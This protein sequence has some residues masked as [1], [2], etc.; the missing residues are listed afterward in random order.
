MMYSNSSLPYF[1]WSVIRFL[2]SSS[3]EEMFEEVESTT[4]CRETLKSSLGK[5]DETMREA[6]NLDEEADL[7][8]CEAMFSLLS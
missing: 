2:R 1:Y 4:Q 3:L 7:C 8:P 6:P 5:V